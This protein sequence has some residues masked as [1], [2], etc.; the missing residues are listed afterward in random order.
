MSGTVLFVIVLLLVL[1]IYAAFSLYLLFNQ[2]RLI[3]EPDSHIAATPDQRGYQYEHVTFTTEDEIKLEGWYVPSPQNAGVILFFHGNT[4]NISHR[5]ET[6]EILH[7]MGFNVFI[8]D[9]RGYGRSQGEP[10]EH[11]TFLDAKAALAY[12]TQVKKIPENKVILF[13]RSLGGAIAVW[14]ASQSKPKALIVESSFTSIPELGQQHYPWLP[15]KLISSFRYDSKQHIQKVSS[16]VLII[17]SRS[18]EVIPFNH[19]QVLF[20]NVCTEKEMLVI[21]G[22]HGDGFIYSGKIY[23]EGLR[24]FLSRHSNTGK[25]KSF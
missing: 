17:H 20:D 16:P 10:S 22:H 12:L 11:G 21:H 19:G 6:L 8:F 14:L 15:V 25:E 4:G 24:A 2:K 9:Y 18:D 7:L 5:F 13:G 3:Y 23:T 1:G